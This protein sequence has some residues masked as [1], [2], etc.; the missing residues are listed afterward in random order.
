MLWPATRRANPLA[1]LRRVLSTVI[2]P[3]GFSVASIGPP[4]V[5]TPSTGNSSQLQ[6]SD[7]SPTVSDRAPKARRIMPFCSSSRIK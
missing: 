7:W 3:E 2:V 5:M 6:P 1:P 4:A